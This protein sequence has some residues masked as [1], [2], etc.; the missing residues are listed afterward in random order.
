MESSTNE[1][2]THVH[3]LCAGYDI[4]KTLSSLTVDE[5]KA[6]YAPGDLIVFSEP[7]KMSETMKAHAEK[8]MPLEVEE[9][10]VNS[11]VTS[12]IHHVSCDK[13]EDLVQIHIDRYR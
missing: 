6:K 5:I 2:Q 11:L 12:K 8:S 9:G 10:V 4:V 13:V 1:S 7:L 3:Y